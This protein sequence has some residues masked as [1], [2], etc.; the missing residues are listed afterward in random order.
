MKLPAFILTVMFF[1]TAYCFSSELE[2]CKAGDIIKF[3]GQNWR[4]LDIQDDHALIITEN[5]KIIGR[6]HYHHTLLGITWVNSSMR[7][8]LNNEYLNNFSAEER[9][10]IRE[11]YIAN[12]NNPW[13]GTSGGGGT[14]DRVF[15]LSAEEAVRYFGD[16]GQLQSRP[17]GMTWITD[18][19]DSARIGRDEEGNRAFWWLRTPGAMPH[20]ASAI[21]ATGVIWL[22]GTGVS[23]RPLGAR[24]ALW[25]KL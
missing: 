23:N 10:R 6:G 16:S 20:L 4:V 25:L 22:Y 3:G 5:V 9:S 24:P 18:M 14:M 21:D 7:I 13:F 17:Q 2:T 12:N 19:Y 11:T 1:L 15:L 8:Y